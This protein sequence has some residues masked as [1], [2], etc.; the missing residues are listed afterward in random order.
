MGD[1]YFRILEMHPEIKDV[2]R[3]G[4]HVVWVTPSGTALIVDAN[5]GK[6]KLE[7]RRDRR[8]C[9]RRRSKPEVIRSK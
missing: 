6:E 3:L 7:R 5:D 1:A 8:R 9:S 4:N 2:F